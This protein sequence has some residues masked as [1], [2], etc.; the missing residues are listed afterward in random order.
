MKRILFFILVLLSCTIYAQQ[1]SDDYNYIPL[2]KF[3]TDT[4][5]Y[6]KDNFEAQDSYFKGKKSG[7]SF[8]VLRKGLTYQHRLFRNDKPIIIAPKEKR[9]GINMY[10]LS[11]I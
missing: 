9:H 1:P 6:L 11:F 10:H 5:S 8:E 4:L 3:Q 2:S 7:R